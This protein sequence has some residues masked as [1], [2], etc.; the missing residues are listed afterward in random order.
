MMGFARVREI[1]VS[2]LRL[3]FLASLCSKDFR[4]LIW[5]RHLFP[6]RGS[7]G[8]LQAVHGDKLELEIELT[9][10]FPMSSHTRWSEAIVVLSASSGGSFRNS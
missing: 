2:P 5:L 9:A 1:H 6:G 3:G 4:H 8:V 7:G 10:Q